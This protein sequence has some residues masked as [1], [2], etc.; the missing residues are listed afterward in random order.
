MEGASIGFLLKQIHD[1]M[2]RHANRNLK[3]QGLTFSQMRLLVLLY[4]R[5]SAPSQKELE[6]QMGVTH[7]TVVGLIKRLEGKGLVRCG[8][9]SRDK[10]VKSVYLTEEGRGFMCKVR[11]HHDLMESKITA[12]M[13]P[14]E[15]ER[16]REGL[17]KVLQ[18]V[19]I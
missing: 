4:V 2:D 15:I 14:E 17:C 8:F 13:C 18:N 16:L 7:P 11:Q 3:P 19:R 6:E 5:P 1:N 10:R 12:G 9:D